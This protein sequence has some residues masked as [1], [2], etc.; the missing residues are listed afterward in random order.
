MRLKMKC[1]SVCQPWA[2]LLAIGAK[3]YETRSWSAH[4]RGPMLIHA[5]KRLDAAVRNLCEC[6]PFK[7]ALAMGGYPSA[8][9]LPLGQV[10]AEAI[11]VECYQVDAIRD[12]LCSSE[13]AFGDY[14]HGRYVWLLRDVRQLVPLPLAGRLGLFEAQ[15]SVQDLQARAI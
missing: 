2:T 15:V 3:R 4:Y 11:L 6:E 5:S 8:D 13:L 14:R 12:T 10:I 7:S 9:Q 1:L